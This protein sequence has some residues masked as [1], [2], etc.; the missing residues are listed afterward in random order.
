MLERKW[1]RDQDRSAVP[2]S[3][4]QEASIDLKNAYLWS[5][6]VSII[7]QLIRNAHIRTRFMAWMWR[8]GVFA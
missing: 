3:I 7:S 8:L 6:A 2:A 1:R 4:K 5:A